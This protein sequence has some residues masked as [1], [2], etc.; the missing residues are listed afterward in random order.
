MW[1]CLLCPAMG[2]V[3]TNTNVCCFDVGVSSSLSNKTICSFLSTFPLITGYWDFQCKWSY[4]FEVCQLSANTNVGCFDVGVSSLPCDKTICSFLVILLAI[5]TFNVNENMIFKSVSFCAN[6]NVRSCYEGLS[7]SPS[8]KT[9][10]SLLVNFLLLLATETLNVNDNMIYKW[11]RLVQILMLVA[12]MW[13]CLPR[14][15]IR[16]IVHF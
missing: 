3:S 13:A 8:N 16:P 12:L 9:I 10:C 2:Q 14:P 5:E 11:V 15:A 7:S 4:D 1:A 6:L